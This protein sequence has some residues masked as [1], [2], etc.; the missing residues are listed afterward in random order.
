M[1]SRA[2]AYFVAVAE[3]RN[4]S[5]AADRLGIS[6]PSLSRAMQR[7]ERRLGVRLLDR[8]SRQVLLT[9]PGETL[10]E[11]GRKALAAL[12]AAENATRRAGRAPRRLTVAMKPGGDGGLLPSV[13]ARFADRPD[14]DTVGA[15]VEVEVLLCGIGGETALLRDG[16]ADLALLRL[17]QDDLAGL[18]TEELL[19]EREVAVLPR[20][21][22][23]AGASCLRMSDLV[24]E[25]FPRWSARSPGEGPLITDT[26][27]IAELIALGRMIALL[28][29]SVARRLGHGLLTVPVE[30]RRTTLLAVWPADRDDRELAAFLRTAAD[31]AATHPAA[32]GAPLADMSHHIAD[33]ADVRTPLRR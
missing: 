19:T 2:L 22:R 15:D 18:D 12:T 9:R 17:P 20:T 5:R 26:G 21:H 27:Q 4:F 16:T 8:T 13:L 14:A 33:A 32:A 1:D 10:L 30:N 6:Q 3:E 23:L 29:E 11:E 28:P 7:L 25:V 31:V 24:G